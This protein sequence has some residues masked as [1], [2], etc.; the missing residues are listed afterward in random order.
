VKGIGRSSALG[1]RL[2]LLVAASVTDLRNLLF[3]R[4]AVGLI[5]KDSCEGT[6]H[7]LTNKTGTGKHSWAAWQVICGSWDKSRQPPSPPSPSLSLHTS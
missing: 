1:L 2:S 5:V 7:V 3:S 6:G 4:D